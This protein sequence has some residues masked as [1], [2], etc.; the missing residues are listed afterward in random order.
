MTTTFIRNHQYNYI[1][2]QSD[3]V[4]KTLRSVADR[5]VLETVR[6]SAEVN[7]TEAFSSLTTEQEQMLKPIS[8][9]EKAEDFQQYISGFE[10][11]LEPFPPITLKQIQKLFPKNKK[12]KLPDLASFDFRYVTYLAWADIATNKL[13]IV[14]PYEGQFIGVEGRIIPTH[15]KGYCLFCNR[16][17]E[18][19]FLTVKTKPELASA[20]NIASVGQYVCIDNHGCNQSIT[21]IS[22]LERFVLSVQK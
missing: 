11:Y 15:K 12:M 18:L 8:T 6:Y 9:L 16:Q 3:F 7:V 1:K 10:P 2:K 21:N 17:Q 5:R 14:Y 20:D 13:F 22:S 19:A 4:L